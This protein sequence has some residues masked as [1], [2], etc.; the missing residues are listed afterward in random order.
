MIWNM[1]ESVFLLDFCYQ[2]FRS[3]KFFLQ[4][5]TPDRIFQVFSSTIRKLHEVFMIL[6]SSTAYD[7]I[8]IIQVHFFKTRF[9]RSLGI[10]ES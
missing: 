2:T 10:L 8:Q 9:N 3:V 1:N 6:V 7:G 5:W 4:D